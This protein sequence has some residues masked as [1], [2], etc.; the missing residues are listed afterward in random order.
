MKPCP[1]CGEQERNDYALIV[2][3]DPGNGTRDDY[4]CYVSCFRC[5]TEGPAAKSRSAA[6]RKWNIRTTNSG[7]P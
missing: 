1:F 5:L 2:V 6:V 7:N 4:W 3:D